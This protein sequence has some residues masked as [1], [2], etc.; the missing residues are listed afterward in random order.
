MS[1]FWGGKSKEWWVQQYAKSHTNKINIYCHAV[2]IPM[3]AVSILLFLFQT[4]MALGASL[5]TLP[6]AFTPLGLFTIGWIFQFV[7]HY[8]EGKP[9]EF[10][11][12]ARFLLVGLRWWF[13]KVL[14]IKLF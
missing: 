12:D 2:G 14:H 1:A 9:P 11:S 4:F 10:F 6:W 3:I 7:G 5:S 8:F 13:Y